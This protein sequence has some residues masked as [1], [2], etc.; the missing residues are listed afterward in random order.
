MGDGGGGVEASAMGTEWEKGKRN[1]LGSAACLSHYLF[2]LPPP[3]PPPPLHPPPS[4]VVS[5]SSA[6][7]PPPPSFLLS[8]CVQMDVDGRETARRKHGEGFYG[9]AAQTLTPVKSGTATL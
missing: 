8:L 9:T 1:E 2:S 5:A 6:M 3:H 4:H 7:T